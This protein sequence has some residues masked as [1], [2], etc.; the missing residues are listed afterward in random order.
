MRSHLNHYW[1]ALRRRWNSLETDRGDVPGWVLVTLVTGACAH[2]AGRGE[3]RA[4][5]RW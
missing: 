3:R 5:S 4:W 1:A 2:P